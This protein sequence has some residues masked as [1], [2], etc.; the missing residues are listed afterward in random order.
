MKKRLIVLLVCLLFGNVHAQSDLLQRYR[1]MALE[2]NHDFKAAQKSISAS[3]ELQK[4]AKADR[5]P[6]VDGALNFQYTGNPMELTL[7]LPTMGAPVTFAGSDLGYGA[8]ISILQ[9]IYTG[10]RV[11]ESI[12]MAE[13]KSSYAV[14]QSEVIRSQIYFQTDIQYWNTVAFAEM[15]AISESFCNSMTTLAKV[16][17][18]RVEVGLTDPQDLLMVEVKFNDAQ[19]RLLQ[20]QN[21]FETSRMAL[22]LLIG[23]ELSAATQIDKQVPSDWIS[24]TVDLSKADNRPE[25]LMAKTNVEM[26]QSA[27]KWN[28]SKYKPQVYVGVEG[29][30]SS[31]GFNFKPDLDLNYAL[32]AKVSVPIFEWG[33]RRSEK[34]AAKYNI[35]IATDQLNKVVDAVQLETQT[36]QLNL[37]QAE[38][39]VRLSENSLAKA[40]ENEQKALERYNEGKASIVEVIDAQL[41]KQTSR[42]NYLEAKLTMQNSYSELLRVLNEYNNK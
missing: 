35:G 12:R 2:Y 20:S 11:L 26:Q 31:P 4:S 6:K 38:Q 19:Y 33:K 3:I 23:T 28:D 15:V 41:Y 30:Y 40:D 8:A 24:A 34:H 9:P 1:K 14:S 29:S 5:K 32:Y 39:R 10:G 36:A 42:M 16:I 27:L 37:M 25:I 18:E 13:H 22:N 21:S 7:N 17:K